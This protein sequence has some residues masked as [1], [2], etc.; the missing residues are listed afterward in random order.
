MSVSFHQIAGMTSSS[1][2]YLVYNSSD[3]YSYTTIQMKFLVETDLAYI[4]TSDDNSI[5]SLIRLHAFSSEG[6]QLGFLKNEK[7][8]KCIIRID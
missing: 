6:L 2:H 7:Y 5:K 4:N 3:L 1:Y 8:V